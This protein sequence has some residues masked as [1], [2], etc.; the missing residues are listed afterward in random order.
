MNADVSPRNNGSIL[1]A[2]AGTLMDRIWQTARRKRRPLAILTGGHDHLVR[3]LRRNGCAILPSYYDAGRCARMVAEIDHIVETQ[4]DAV[5]RDAMDADHRVFGAERAS[6]ILAEFH[7][8]PLLLSVGEAY[9]RG[10]LRNFSTLAGRL[11]PKSGN[12]GSGQGWHRDAFHFQFKAMVYLTDVT[13]Q[14]GPF[15]FLSG[16]HRALQVVRDTIAGHLDGIP[17]SRITEEQSQRL[18]AA[19]PARLQTFAAKRGTVILFD[20][21][22]IHRGAPIQSGERYALTNYYFEPDQVTPER[23]SEFAPFARAVPHDSM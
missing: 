9:R 17:Q 7:N 18:I 20:S 4:P 15:Q 3:Q 21:S 12:L 23:F 13:P 19:N 10:P 22:G 14:S 6:S 16:S 8:D 2:A 11:R 1:V 5:R